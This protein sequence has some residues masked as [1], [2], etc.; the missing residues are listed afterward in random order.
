MNVHA[1][2]LIM[3]N[4]KNSVIRRKEWPEDN[5]V[6]PDGDIFMIHCG[7]GPLFFSISLGEMLAT[8]WEVIPKP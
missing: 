1:A 7:L 6:L 8:D 5:Y 2:C 3:A 4:D